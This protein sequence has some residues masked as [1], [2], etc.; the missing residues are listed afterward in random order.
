MTVTKAERTAIRQHLLHDQYS[1]ERYRITA[2]GE[3]HGY[4]PNEG[5]WLF[6]GWI[7][8]VLAEIRLAATIKAQS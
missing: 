3:V 7:E 6:C 2:D 1:F 5:G 4:K 8:D